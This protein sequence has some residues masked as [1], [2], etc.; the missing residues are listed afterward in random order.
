M[1]R[2]ETNKYIKQNFA[3]SW[4]Y[5]RQHILFSALVLR[6]CAEIPG[7]VQCEALKGRMSV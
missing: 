2:R 5:L 4:T 1:H 3:P 6:K 7:Q